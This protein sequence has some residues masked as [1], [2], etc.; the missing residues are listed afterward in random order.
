MTPISREIRLL[1]EVEKI[2]IVHDLDED[3]KLDVSE[4][5][6]YLEHT[7]FPGRKFELSEI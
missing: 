3:G 5:A 2:W 4:L 7:A 6:Q 1:G